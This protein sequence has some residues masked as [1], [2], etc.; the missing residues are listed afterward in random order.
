MYGRSMPGER[1]LLSLGYPPR[2]LCS[3]VLVTSYLSLL[4]GGT[5]LGSDYTHHRPSLEEVG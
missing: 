1:I 3:Q 4:F 2:V 5:R